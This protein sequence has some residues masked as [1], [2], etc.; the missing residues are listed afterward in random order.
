MAN[1]RKIGGGIEEKKRAFRM[2]TVGGAA[3]F[4]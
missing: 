1:A 2:E 4:L 3:G